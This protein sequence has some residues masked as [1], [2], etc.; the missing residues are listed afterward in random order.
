[1]DQLASFF[2]KNL[3]AVMLFITAISSLFAASVGLLVY[4]AQKGSPDILAEYG[5]GGP[6]KPLTQS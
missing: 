3:E 2:W 1:M 6:L 5:H 4:R